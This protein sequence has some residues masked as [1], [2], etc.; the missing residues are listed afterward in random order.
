[1]P[2][3]GPGRRAVTARDVAALS[4]RNLARNR[5]R[6]ALSLA[7]VAAGAAALVVTAGFVRFSFDGLREAMIHGGLGHLEIADAAAVAGRVAALDRPPSPALAGW[8]EL[9]KRLEAESAPSGA[10]IVAVGANLHLMGLAQTADGRSASFVGVGVEPDRERAMGF[11]TRVRAGDGLPDSPSPP[12][13]E[14]A[15]VARGLAESLGVGPGD[16]I[17]LVAT[18]DTGSLNAL[19]VRI[20]GVIT[21]GVAELD[22]RYLKL[23]LAAAQ[24]LAQTE[25]V[26]NL[27][28]GL[29]DTRG[30]EA[31]L[32][33]VRARLAE[34]PT[35]GALAVTPWTERAP[36][37]AQV[38]DLY[39]GIFVFLG[40]I[41]VVL[42]VLAASNTL[43]MAVLERVREIGT[44]RAIGTSRGQ[45]AALIVAEAAWLGLIGAVLG[46]GLGL[47]AILGLNAAGLRMPP[48]PGAVDPIDLRLA[49]VPDAFLGAAALLVAVLL[50][51]AIVP[52]ARAA[53]LSIVDALGH[54]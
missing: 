34:P 25:T 21:T 50:V 2:D 12:G 29:D 17:T 51:A 7:V 23:Q 18:T 1:M 28:V 32:A 36:F 46:G 6:T 33:A 30:T 44:L 43:V 19:D 10:R 40:T 54:V 15:L 4:L 38:R 16:T 27:L 11:E 48:P 31:A 5:R 20:A 49:I 52:A 37:Y 53:R 13:D 8:Q 39:L 41:V 42:V 47:V 24:R 9:R 22:T 35:A 45:I 3:A 26:S 14:S